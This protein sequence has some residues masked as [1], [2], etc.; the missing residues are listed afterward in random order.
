[1]PRILHVVV[2]VGC[3][4]T[5]GAVVRADDRAP[6]C[7]FSLGREPCVAGDRDAR[8][9]ERVQR[10]A[11]DAR[12]LLGQVSS[13]VCEGADLFFR[14]TFDGNG[15]T[16]GSCHPADNNYTLDADFIARLSDRDALFIAERE[17]ALANL[18]IPALLR[19]FG[20]V[21]VNA[22]GFEDPTQRFVVRSVSHMLGLST[23]ITAPPLR[24]NSTVF[25]VDST[26]VPPRERLGWSGDGAPGN[27]ELRDFADGAIEQHMTRS[28]ERVRGVDFGLPTDAERD[29]IAAFSRSIGRMQDIDVA[30]VRLADEAAERGRVTFLTGNGI[31]CSGRCHVDAGAN[32]VARAPDGSLVDFGNTSLNIGTALHRLAEVD[33]LGVPLDGGFARSAF[34]L[35]GDGVSDSFGNGAMNVPPLIEAAD[36]APMFHSHAFASLEAAIAFYASEDFARSFVGRGIGFDNREPGEPMPLTP[37]DVVELGRFLRV[38]NAALNVQMASRRIRAALEIARAFAD[39]QRDLQH[40]LMRLAAAEIEDALQVLGEASHLAVRERH[41]LRL[42][43]AALH[44]ARACGSDVAERA[45]YLEHASTLLQHIQLGLGSGL[46]MEIGEGTLMF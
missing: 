24:P 3:L 30:A 36:T 12:V 28:L 11:A 33:A 8:A 46:D 4:S 18:E 2:V 41:E 9:A 23:S 13:H 39:E 6:R 10:C 15:R 31:E 43:R 22:D 25:A 5:G 1:M 45:A 7:A 20:L 35:D 40:G 26:L 37:A 38:A 32:A 27:G 16:C 21:L 34:D 14:E 17:P 44:A 29:A 42:T 19:D